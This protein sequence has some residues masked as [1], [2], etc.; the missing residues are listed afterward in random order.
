L[1]GSTQSRLNKYFDT[2]AFVRAPTIPAG[3][4]IAG[5]YPVSA[6]GTVFGNTGLNI[7]RGPGQRNLDLG[8]SKKVGLGEN[9]KLEFRTELFNALNQTNFG[10]PGSGI[11]TPTT[12]GVISETT[13]APRVIQFALRFLF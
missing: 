8:I 5:G 9:R 13:A 4:T 12:F 3:G 10:L 11:G 7:L 1:S 2:A 6:A